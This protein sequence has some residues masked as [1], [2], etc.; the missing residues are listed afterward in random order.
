MLV[1]GSRALSP[2]A[3]AE[4]CKSETNGQVDVTPAEEMQRETRHTTSGLLDIE[5]RMEKY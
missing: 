3:S 4:E 1:G 5:N 2:G